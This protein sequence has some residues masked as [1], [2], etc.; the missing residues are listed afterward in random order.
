VQVRLTAM[1]ADGL[2]SWAASSRAGF[3]QQQVAS[4]SMPAPEATEYAQRAFDALLPQGV[5]S[6]GQH[7]WDV[8]WGDDRV[9]HVWVQISSH[10]DGLDAFVF[11]VDLRP[12]SRG[13]GL[14]RAAMLAAE[15]EVRRMGV[16]R[17]RLNVFGHNV[18]ALRLYDGL[19]Y[20]PVATMLSK[21]LRLSEPAA[22]EVPRLRLQPLPAGDRE[23]YRSAVQRAD[24][25]RMVRSGMLP[26]PEARQKAADDWAA[27]A[28]GGHRGVDHRAWLAYD[29]AVEVGRVWLQ[30][31]P[32]SDEEHVLALDLSPVDH[33]YRPALL[34]AAAEVSRER[35]A[36]ALDASV[37]ACEPG[38]QECFEEAGYTVTARLLRKDLDRAGARDPER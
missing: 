5:N 34:L 1:T 6:P 3:A 35:G 7:L 9:G 11:D 4:G 22:G 12:E 26:A 38:V 25:E 24:A 36:V 2:S 14:G 23:G 29:G 31:L 16:R 32:R 15:S 20:R 21:D 37:F 17:V 19:G 33:G 18:A 10:S 13:R 8:Q 27:L 30:S 28:R